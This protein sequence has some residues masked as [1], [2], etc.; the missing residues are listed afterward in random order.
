M[1]EIFKENKIKHGLKEIK[2]NFDGDMY[3]AALE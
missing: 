1:V 3:W 2:F